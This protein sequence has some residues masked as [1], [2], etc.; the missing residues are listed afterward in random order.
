MEDRV[1]KKSLIYGDK[2]SKFFRWKA[3]LEKKTP[4]NGDKTSKSFRW[5]AESKRNH[6]VMVIRLQTPIR[7]QSQNDPKVF[8]RKAGSII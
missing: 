4:S 2:T 5:K 6:P 1:K 3:K 8:W 7:R